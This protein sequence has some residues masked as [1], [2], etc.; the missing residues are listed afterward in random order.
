LIEST[1]IKWFLEQAS[2]SLDLKKS[3]QKHS[4]LS[5]L[6]GDHQARVHSDQMVLVMVKREAEPHERRP[7]DAQGRVEK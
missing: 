1:Q 6:K 3:G 7:K 4:K 2:G 5:L